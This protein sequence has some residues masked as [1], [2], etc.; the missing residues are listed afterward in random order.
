V[1]LTLYP[2]DKGDCFL[3]ESADGRRLLVDGGMRGSYT[4]H[5]AGELGRLAE[6]GQVLDLVCISHIDQDHISG[7]LQLLDDHVAWKVHRYQLDEKNDRHRPP[8]VSP[9][10][11]I[12][13]IWHNAFGEQVGADPTRSEEALVAAGVL[14]AGS[15]DEALFRPAE[16][17]RE[18]ATSVAEA[19]RVSRRLGPEQL[20]IEVNAG[21]DGPVRVPDGGPAPASDLGSMRITVIAPLEPQLEALRKEWDEW[22]QAN[23]KALA[24]IRRDAEEDESSFGLGAGGSIQPMIDQAA[25]LA[26][27][28]GDIN[29][30][31]VPNLA[32]IM[33]LVE[34]GDSSMLLTGDGHASHALEG[35]TLAGKL[36]E[37]RGIHVNVLK[38]QHHGSEYNLMPEFTRKVTADHYVFCADGEYA[39][40]DLRVLRAI[41]DSRLGDSTGADLDAVGTNPEVADPFTLWFN[42]GPD[43]VTDEKQVDHLQAVRMLADER[44]AQSN[45][46]MTVRF[47]PTPGPDGFG[48][49]VFES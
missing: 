32:S 38:V 45:G 39:N 30:V 29:R 46:R 42:T 9:P 5:V 24:N 21:F 11:E 28:L 1:R 22:L 10:P 49:V 25:A 13:G 3:V 36:T 34:E 35:L 2:S 43:L 18:L 7:I 48:W 6:Q 19:I 44:A 16:D 37:E 20:G 4:D 12:S 47:R 33:L 26:T 41:I 8:K 14:L 23:E 40:P 15:D 17:R 31:T 27:E